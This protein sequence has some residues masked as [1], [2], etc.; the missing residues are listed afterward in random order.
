[1]ITLAKKSDTQDQYVNQV[2][3]VAALERLSGEY[4]A[5][6]WYATAEIVHENSLLGLADFFYI[7][8]WNAGE[9]TRVL[10]EILDRTGIELDRKELVPGEHCSWTIDGMY[11]CDW[12]RAMSDE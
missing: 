9:K 7:Q 12:V 10:A 6:S 4:T 5:A 2:V 8:K 3:S 11:W 1:M